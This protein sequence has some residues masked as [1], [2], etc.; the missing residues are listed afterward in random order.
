MLVSNEPA[1]EPKL[2][3]IPARVLL[4][5]DDVPLRDVIA[6]EIRDQGLDVVE[7]TDGIE[8]L[9]YFR[10]AAS[11]Y[12]PMM[13]DVVVA[14]MDLP[15]CSGIEACSRL[16]QAGSRVPIILLSVPGLAELHEAA[17]EAGAALVVDRPF[18]LEAL[19][20]MVASAARR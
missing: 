16:R 12:L 9:E 18:S 6:D 3:P 2:V 1:G 5:E 4:V 7:L 11:S 13:P 15:G 10:G 20:K 17:R 8:L 19:A 14:E